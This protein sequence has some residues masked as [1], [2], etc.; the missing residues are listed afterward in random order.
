MKTLIIHPEDQSTDPLCPIYE[1]I[2]NKRVIRGGVSKNELL[3]AV[4]SH[5]RIIMMG[6]GSPLGLFAVGKFEQESHWAYIIDQ[7]FVSALQNKDNVFIWCHA[8]QFVE[9]HQL[10]GFYSGMFISEEIEAL[11]HEFDVNQE[12]VDNSNHA[13]SHILSKYINESSEIIHK[14]VTHEYGALARCNP[15]VEYNNNKLKH[16]PLNLVKQIS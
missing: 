12:T 5:Q 10:T 15:I 2:K 6:H 9:Q 4:E 14:N 8:N 3:K 11:M 1:G 7:T 16:N 13:F